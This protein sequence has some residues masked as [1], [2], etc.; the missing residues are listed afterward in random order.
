MFLG[1]IWCCLV[2]CFLHHSAILILCSAHI[3]FHRHVVFFLI[4]THTFHLCMWKSSFLLRCQLPR[5]QGKTHIFLLFGISW[6]GC[7]G[8]FIYSRVGEPGFLFPRAPGDA[9]LSMHTE[10]MPRGAQLPWLMKTSSRLHGSIWENVTFTVFNSQSLLA[11]AEGT[12]SILG[13]RSPNSCPLVLRSP[14]NSSVAFIHSME[15][16]HIQPSS[17][18]RW[19]S[20]RTRDRLALTGGR[21]GKDVP[22]F[23]ALLSWRYWGVA[24]ENW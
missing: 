7:H 23:K 22:I 17:R 15:K 24:P 6:P 11:P 18:C 4:Y 13:P 8:R 3:S 9:G 16:G 10:V 2:P 1:N 12:R 14:S 5:S 20:S 21:V 19:F